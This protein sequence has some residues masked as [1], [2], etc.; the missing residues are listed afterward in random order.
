MNNAK[1]KI[2]AF[3]KFLIL[4]IVVLGVAG[5]ELAGGYCAITYKNNSTIKDRNW[6]YQLRLRLYCISL[7]SN[8]ISTIIIHQNN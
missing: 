2:S 3:V 1:L 5:G 7:N 6:K 8:F 4:L